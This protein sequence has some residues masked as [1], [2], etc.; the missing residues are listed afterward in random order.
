VLRPRSPISL[1]TLARMASF[2]T[3]TRLATEID[4]PLGVFATPFDIY[5]AAVIPWLII[6]SSISTPLA[7]VAT[8][9]LRPS[10]SALTAPESS[11]SSRF[12]GRPVDAPIAAAFG[13]PLWMPALPFAA[14]APA[15]NA[16]LFT[17]PASSCPPGIPGPAPLSGT[18]IAGMLPF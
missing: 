1:A 8:L 12:V 6:A 3:L 4:F 13:S 7:M 10:A 9:R 2:M 5:L 14:R 15:I 11:L 17:Q 16:S 18:L